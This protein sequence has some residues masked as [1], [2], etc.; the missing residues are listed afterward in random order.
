[1]RKG[2][3]A[4]TLIEMLIA[5]SIFSI[6]MLYLYKTYSTLNISNANLE[7]EVSK[8]QKIQ[9]IKKVIFLDFTLGIFNPRGM[10]LINNR[11]KNEDFVVL[12]SS[13]SLHRRVNPYVTYIVKDKILYRLESLKKFRS[14]EL[15]SD[16]KFDVDVIGEVKS[17]RI[18]KT[19][20]KTQSY[21]VAIKFKSMD[22][23]LLKVNPLNEY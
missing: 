18:Y 7:K 8:I 2:R 14:Y 9:K 12:Q 23:I 4:F 5:V 1:M 17:F 6:M 13:H 11:E 22:D 15:S 21:L 3:S 10:V 20:K 19:T 16:A